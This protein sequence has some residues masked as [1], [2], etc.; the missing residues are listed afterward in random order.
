MGRKPLGDKKRIRINLAI[1]PEVNERLDLA[2]ERTG[3]SR[4]RIVEEA[5]V[6][7]LDKLEG[8]S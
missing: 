1:E 4:S 7:H 8:K 6:V 2:S 3:K 5:L